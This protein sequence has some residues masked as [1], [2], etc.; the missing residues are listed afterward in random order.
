[1]SES[2]VAPDIG[3]KPAPF[4]FSYHCTVARRGSAGGSGKWVNGLPAMTVCDAGCCVIAGRV[5]AGATDNI[6][7][8]RSMLPPLNVALASV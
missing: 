3:V 1:V 8:I 4:T 6:A 2:D 5:G 7:A